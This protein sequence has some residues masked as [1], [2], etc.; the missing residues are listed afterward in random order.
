[1]GEIVQTGPLGASGFWSNF[2]SVLKEAGGAGFVPRDCRKAGDGALCPGDPGG[3]PHEPETGKK[4]GKIETTPFG[5]RKNNVRNQNCHFSSFMR[6]WFPRFVS[7]CNCLLAAYAL[8]SSLHMMSTL[9]SSAGRLDS[10]GVE[11]LLKLTKG[12][13]TYEIPLISLWMI[14]VSVILWISPGVSKTE[15]NQTKDNE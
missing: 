2:W 8:K 10:R 6:S 13:V 7:V 11:L 14:C 12:L 9:P 1:M 3:E 5:N 4:A 15:N